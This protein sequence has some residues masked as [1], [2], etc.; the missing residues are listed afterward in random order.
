MTGGD[1]G[2]AILSTT[3]QATNQNLWVLWM[4]KE[5]SEN[6]SKYEKTPLIQ[7]AYGDDKP[8]KSTAVT[9]E[10]LENPDVSVIIAPTAVGMLAAGRYLQ[11]NDSEVLLTGLGLPSEMAPFIESGVCPW[12][13]LWNPV[14]LGYLTAYTGNALVNRQITGAIGDT[15]FAG[16]M[17]ERIITAA[18][19]GGTEVMLGDP[20]KFDQANIAVWKEVY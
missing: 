18:A 11:D 16:N 7:I 14:D 17:G 4:E 5:Y 12:M 20:F 19:D 8:V 10:L 13:Y 15:F 1:G 2:I 6:A 3:R 9:E